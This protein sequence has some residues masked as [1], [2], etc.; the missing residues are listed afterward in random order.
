MLQTNKDGILFILFDQIISSSTVSQCMRVWDNIMCWPPTPAGQLSVLP[1]PSHIKNIDTSSK[2]TK[3]SVQMHACS[4]SKLTVYKLRKRVCMLLLIFSL[5]R[6]IRVHVNCTTIL[7]LFRKRL[8]AVYGGR[9]VVGQPIQQ[10]NLD[11]L[12]PVYRYNNGR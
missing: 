7:Y 8:P 5:K 3:T 10:P 4:I 9:H 11:Q 1:C 2:S 12:Y 6:E